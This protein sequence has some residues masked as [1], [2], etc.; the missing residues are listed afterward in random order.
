MSRDMGAYRKSDLATP[1]RLGDSLS[2]CR[3]AIFAVACRRDAYR[4]NMMSPVA[5]DTRFGAKKGCLQKKR[6]RRVAQCI[7]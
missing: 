7:F 6:L 5:G 4:Q 3:P 1:E 2:G